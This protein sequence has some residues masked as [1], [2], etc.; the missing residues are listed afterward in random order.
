MVNFGIIGCGNIAHKFADAVHLVDE[1]VLKGCASKNEARAKAFAK[2]CNV[3]IA[4]KDY[5]ELFASPLIDVVYVATTCN[6]HYENIKAALLSGKSVLCEKAMVTTRA[7]AEELFALAR[8]K[9]LFLFEGMWSL[10]L[11][12]VQ[13][14]R[15]WVLTGRVGDVSLAYYFGGINAPADNRIFRSDLG[16]GAFLDLTVYPYEV[17]SFMLGRPGKLIKA[18]VR[19]EKGVD[20]VNELI[21]DFDGIRGMI[22]TTAYAR[23]PSPSGIFGNKGYILIEQTHRS[24][25][26]RLFDG[27]FGL[28]EEFRSTVV[29]GF[30][31][32]VVEAVKLFKEKRTAS[33]IST[34][35]MTMAFM[36]LMEEAVD[37][38]RQ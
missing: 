19:Y 36:A 3:E 20:T 15:E 8:E 10:F 25:T 33:E 27:N 21:V 24:D 9:G 6:F 18:D 5:E 29:N 31:Y 34:P 37:E 1:A 32:E 11:P 35:Q 23:I 38:T 7:E 12:T 2:E 14:A 26:V 4:F 16:G 22:A 17:L 28:V 13:K 30:E